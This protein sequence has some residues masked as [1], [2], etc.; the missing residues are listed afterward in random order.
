MPAAA[1]DP[2]R[3]LS[4]YQN[5]HWQTEQGLPQST[6]QAMTETR[7]GYLWIGTLDGLARFDGVRF[8]VFDARAVPALG[9]GSVLGLM[10]DAEGNLW[11]GRS[12][13]AV[14][15]RDGRFRVAFGDEVTAG[16]AVWSFCQAK[17]GA[18]WAATNNGLV[19]WAKGTTRVF[20]KADGLPTDRLRSLAFDR[21]G[22]LWIGTHRRRPRVVFGRPVRSVRSRERLSA[23][24]SPLGHRRP[25]GR[26]LG[27]DGGR[28]SGT[29]G[30]TARSPPTPWRTAFRPTSSRPSRST[31]TARS[32]SGRGAPGSAG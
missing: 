12:G 29:R 21:D 11:I 25:V 2:T 18:V 16:D 23:R 32:G 10:Q 3:A 31:R 6:V 13:A 5:D 15:Y 7:D 20:Q 4:Q 19:R 27:G 8:T 26:H 28:W 17:D 22:T 30:A 24:R 14:I 9:S 1:L